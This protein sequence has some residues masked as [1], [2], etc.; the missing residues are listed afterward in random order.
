M[1]HFSLYTVHHVAYENTIYNFAFSL[2]KFAKGYAKK[3]KC[4]S[5]NGF[6][7]LFNYMVLMY[8]LS[9]RGHVHPNIGS[10]K[11]N[12]PTSLAFCAIS[13]VSFTKRRKRHDIFLLIHKHNIYYEYSFLLSLRLSE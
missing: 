1:K 2:S 8:L 7:N 10:N 13:A 3:H 12:P 11:Q 4:S 9:Q 5:I 6:K